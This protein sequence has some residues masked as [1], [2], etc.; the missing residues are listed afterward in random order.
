[1]GLCE[2]GSTTSQASIS[3]YKTTNIRNIENNWH[4]LNYKPFGGLSTTLHQRICQWYVFK[5]T[6]KVCR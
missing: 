2:L 1:M 6:I 5:M 4:Q 3:T